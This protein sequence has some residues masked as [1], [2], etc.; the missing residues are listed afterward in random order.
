MLRHGCL[1]VC[2][3]LWGIP[4]VSYANNGQKALAY[5]VQGI[6][7]DGHISDWPATFKKYYIERSQNRF[8]PIDRTDFYAHFMVGYNLESQSLYLVVE[9]TDDSH[10]TD[11][12]IEAN[13]LNQD[14]HLLYLDI[15]HETKGT[16]IAFYALTQNA[17][18]LINN[19]LSWDQFILDSNINAIDHAVKR[20]GNKTVYEWKIYLG[21]QL[22]VHRTIGLDHVVVDMDEQDENGTYSTMAWGSNGWKS[23]MQNNLGDVFIVDPNTSFGTIEGQVEWG[24]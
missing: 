1:W 10:V 15:Q 13:H 18:R 6:T 23:S 16:G 3:L 21:D 20:T 19:H 5:P 24:E 12:S 4:A 17:L 14:A 22:F 2:L 9:V 7:I 11:A 8:S